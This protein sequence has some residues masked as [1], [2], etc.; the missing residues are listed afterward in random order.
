MSAISWKE[1]SSDC[2]DARKPSKKQGQEF[3]ILRFQ[4][5]LLFITL[6]YILK[7]SCVFDGVLLAISIAC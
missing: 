4:V 5:E 7:A 3:D 1:K 6:Y 2:C